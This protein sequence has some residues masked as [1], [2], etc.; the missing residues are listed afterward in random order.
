[1]GL[2][3]PGRR[4]QKEHVHGRGGL[5]HIAR[6]G[7]GQLIAGPHH[8]ILEGMLPALDIQG[9][10]PLHPR[11]MHGQG[12]LR[13][14]GQHGRGRGQRTGQGFGRQRLR[15]AGLFG[16]RGGG[17]HGQR[18]RDA[19]HRGGGLQNG[20][21]QTVAHPGGHKIVGR[22]Q[23]QLP[24]VRGFVRSSRAAVLHVGRQR[25]QPY[26]TDALRK[27]LPQLEKNLG[28]CRVHGIEVYG[29]SRSGASAKNQRPR[30]PTPRAVPKASFLYLAVFACF[31]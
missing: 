4:A 11:Q 30:L 10:G 17:L 7:V 15:Q 16:A 3:Q 22:G 6:G 27:A 14:G 19:P 24:G 12:Q 29:T 2:A 8:K 26:L 13:G 25:L 28:P 1:M 18:G 21:A 20:L 23:A 9:A 5:E 31:F